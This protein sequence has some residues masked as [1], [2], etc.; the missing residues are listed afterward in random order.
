MGFVLTYAY[1][2][3]RDGICMVL[4]EYRILLAQGYVL[5]P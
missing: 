1:C 3:L 4:A 2:C 5:R